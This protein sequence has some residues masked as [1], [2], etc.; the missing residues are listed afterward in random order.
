MNLLRIIILTFLSQVDA[1][2][3][4]E[5]GKRQSPACGS[6]S[7][8]KFSVHGLE[9]FDLASK[10]IDKPCSEIPNSTATF[11]PYP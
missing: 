8:S 4:K 5:V 7:R 2:R 3:L 11:R 6:P 10:A 9:K 1:D